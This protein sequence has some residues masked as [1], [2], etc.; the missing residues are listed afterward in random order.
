VVLKPPKYLD[1]KLID[2]LP[3]VCF[4]CCTFQNTTST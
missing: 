4:K 1:N 2:L 3:C